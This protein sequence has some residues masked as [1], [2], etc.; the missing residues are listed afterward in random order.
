MLCISDTICTG[1]RRSRNYRCGKSFLET[2]S[3]WEKVSCGNI[4]LEE[5]L[6]TLHSYIGAREE[7][8]RR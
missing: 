4:T 6:I 1:C 7:K 3:Y 5:N 2:K 8:L